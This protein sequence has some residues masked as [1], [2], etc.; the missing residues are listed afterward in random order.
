MSKSTVLVL[1]SILISS[2]CVS[3]G[4]RALHDQNHADNADSRSRS[5][6]FTT[7]VFTN[8]NVDV[9]PDG[10]V[11]VFDVIGN[12][13][14]V[15]IQGG[16]ATQLTQGHAW[17]RQPRFSPDGKRIGY[18]SD[19]SGDAVVWEM[20]LDGSRPVPH[21]EATQYSLTSSLM[22]RWSHDGFL[23][24]V[25]STPAGL[26]IDRS[27]DTLGSGTY[28]DADGRDAVAM[29][30]GE[31]SGDGE[32]LYFGGSG[33]YRKDLGSGTVEKL[34]DGI[35]AKPRLSRDGSML[36]YFLLV[37]D[38][39]R[40]EHDE[41]RC[42]LHAIDLV[43]DVDIEISAVNRDC[44]LDS[45]GEG[46]FDIPDYAMLPDGSAAVITQNGKIFRVDFKT[47]NLEEIP[48]NVV[49]NREISPLPQQEN[50]RGLDQMTVQSR[51]I[52]WPVA[53]ANSER[54]FF[55]AFS[56]I[57]IHDL[58]E[59]QSRRLTSG[60]G[61]ENAPAV[62]PDGNWIAYTTWTD[63]HQG[64]VV[65]ER[66]DGKER[67]QI[68]PEP[69]R[70]INPV[71]SPNGETI[72]FIVD[73]DRN[74]KMGLASS[75]SGA[76]GRGDMQ[77][78]VAS[79]A[80][81]RPPVVIAEVGA[82]GSLMTTRV[83]PVPTFLADGT[84]IALASYVDLAPGQGKAVLMSVG[85]DGKTVRHHYQ[86][87]PVDEVVVSPLGDY[88]GMV[89]QNAL[90][91][92]SIDLEKEH[93]TPPELKI[94]VDSLVSDDGPVHVSWSGSDTLVWADANQIRQYVIGSPKPVLAA[95]IDIRRSRS[96]PD[97]CIAYVGARIITMAEAGVIDKGS[98]LVCGDRISEVGEEG[99]IVI[100]QGVKIVNLVG[101]TI[102]PGL[103][104]THS[105]LHS[106]D[107]EIWST[108]NESYVPFLANGVTT[109]YDPSSPLL[110]PFG[111]AELI[112]VGDVVGPRIYASGP[113]IMYRPAKMSGFATPYEFLYRP[114]ES[115]ESA[116]KVVRSVAR[117]GAGPIKTY[118]VLAREYQ[119]NLSFAARKH[120]VA[121]TSHVEGYDHAM[122]GVI[123]GISIEHP[124]E[125]SAGIELYDDVAKYIALS[126]TPFTRDRYAAGIY[127]RE[128][129]SSDKKLRR[130]ATPSSIRKWS[131][132]E[133]LDELSNNV[134]TKHAQ[135]AA[136]IVE[137]G[138]LVTVASHGNG[139]PGL[140]VHHEIWAL[141][142]RGG[143]S[144]LNALRAGTVNGAK[145]LGVDEDLGSVDV[146]KIADFI[147]MNANPLED[148]RASA[149]IR[150][151]V[152]SG[153]VYDDETMT[154]IWPDYEELTPWP[155]QKEAERNDLASPERVVFPM[156]NYEPSH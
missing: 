146:G 108:Q 76:A 83:Y 47:G 153:F 111:Q 24:K 141:V 14:T 74:A 129:D 62:S 3:S 91:V 6:A 101:A 12:I 56:K 137:L 97:G 35:V 88:V 51:V 64:H 30:Q 25:T 149:D 123:D 115:A 106:F 117:Y 59:G 68:T 130:M 21:N 23:L 32:A 90:H 124:L 152:K 155:W 94:S 2:G 102:M 1:I 92:I 126:G 113:P 82:I 81:D 139:I 57:Y 140:S 93:S 118:Y 112:E 128:F 16:E 46:T 70:Y 71:W 34:R 41:V 53:D 95:E 73:L 10:K 80:G 77:L 119:R 86:L 17:S 5:I 89:W 39:L 9:S 96:R 18:I 37:G 26:A 67:K 55:G 148:I 144:P 49:V 54:F 33:L 69:G 109:V 63:L 66:I 121:I 143:M 103:I 134:S 116:G 7:S 36:S 114:I 147:V 131:D 99:S 87:P 132:R 84:R 13:Y 120:G 104:D 145:K 78:H 22:P 85:I 110:D 133:P 154:R 15:P 48:V 127:E 136:R 27:I 11:I 100:P 98:V 19:A 151:V 142:L 45:K 122:A 156:H 58:K 8:A 40:A 61:F 42:V 38:R 75:R 150:Y 28:F 52:R 72:A 29:A 105:H 79:V 20:R 107:Y 138:G 31:V 125:G 44:R 4:G 60:D 135:F 65:V 43:K 50:R